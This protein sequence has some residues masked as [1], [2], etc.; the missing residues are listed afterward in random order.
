M[1]RADLE[2]SRPS[3]VFQNYFNYFR[4]ETI[5]PADTPMVARQGPSG[6]RWC[7]ANRTH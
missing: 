3:H 2:W 1:S 5:G 7:S 4:P 6:W